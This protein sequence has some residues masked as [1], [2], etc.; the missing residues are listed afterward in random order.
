MNFTREI[1]KEDGRCQAGAVLAVCL[2]ATFLLG[3][4]SF[5]AQIFSR[6]VFPFRN[7]VVSES[8][9]KWRAVF[10]PGLATSLDILEWCSIG[11]AFA[12]V[13]WRVRVPFLFLIAFGMICFAAAT[14]AVLAG[15]SGVGFD[16]GFL[17]NVAPA[18]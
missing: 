2:I 8:T 14:A 17:S 3:Q 12:F 10:S 15:V 6:A 13:F 9:H 4:L 18:H 5:L 11:L 1:S 16:G 7:F